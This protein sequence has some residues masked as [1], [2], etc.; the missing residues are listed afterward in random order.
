MYTSTGFGYPQGGKNCRAGSSRHLSGCAEMEPSKPEGSPF[1]SQ[2]VKS[3]AAAGP[4]ELVPRCVQGGASVL[5]CQQGDYSV[6]SSQEFPIIEPRKSWG[7]VL[8]LPL[9]LRKE[10][11]PTLITSVTPPISGKSFKLSTLL[12]ASGLVK[13]ACLPHWLES[14][15]PRVFCLPLASSPDNHQ[16][17]I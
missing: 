13:H 12:W 6:W 17:P 2:V 11:H 1:T 10:L 5:H 7:G 4:N 16:K 8:H 3:D 14:Q 9:L 15:P